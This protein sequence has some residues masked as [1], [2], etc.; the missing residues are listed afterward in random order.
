VKFTV[1]FPLFIINISVTCWSTTYGICTWYVHLP[2]SGLDNPAIYSEIAGSKSGATPA[3]ILISEDGS[4]VELVVVVLVVMLLPSAAAIW[5]GTFILTWADSIG[6]GVESASIM[7]SL[8]DNERRSSGT[9]E[10]V[11]NS[12]GGGRGAPLLPWILVKT[13]PKMKK[14]YYCSQPS[15]L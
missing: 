3:I 10:V 5:H 8:G 9:V 14:N 6:T 4:W 1:W 11:C 13:I 7:K 15:I 12:S 2:I